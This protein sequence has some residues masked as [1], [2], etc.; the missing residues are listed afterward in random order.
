MATNTG[1]V[2]DVAQLGR[3]THGDQTMQVEVLALF[4]AEAER[5]MR[6][7]E[8]ASDGQVR[9]E[10]LHAL[11]GLARNTGAILVGQ[12]ARASEANIAGESPDFAPLRSALDETL[13][14][15]RRGG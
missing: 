14:Y 2:F 1:P 10:R 5:L 4:V 15:I 8:T 6:Q 13:A 7:L 9:R 3:R 11:I 12:A